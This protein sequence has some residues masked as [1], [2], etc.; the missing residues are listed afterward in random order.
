MA[1]NFQKAGLIRLK[2]APL[3]EAKIMLAGFLIDGEEV[4]GSFQTV[5]DRVVFTDKRIIT[6]DVQGL[7][8]KRKSY[9]SLPYS[10]IQYFSVQTPGLDEFF[11]DSELYMMFANGFTAT[12]NFSDHVDMGLI[13][14]TIAEHTLE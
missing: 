14:R 4:I 6:I 9:A 8:G 7:T 13:S 10:K 11:P 12:F 2:S 1:I 5:R 3:Q